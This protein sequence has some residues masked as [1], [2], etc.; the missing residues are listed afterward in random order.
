MGRYDNETLYAAPAGAA[1]GAAG[2]RY[3]N[4]ALYPPAPPAR[5]PAEMRSAD[6]S[7]SQRFKYAV[8]D[9]LMGLGAKPHVAQHLAEGGTGVLGMTPMGSVLAA[10]DL[11]YNA[12]RGNYVNTALDALGVVPGV[13]AA[14]RIVGGMPRIR[15]AEVPPPWVE[16]GSAE[17]RGW[18]T[19]STPELIGYPQ[20][21]TPGRPAVGLLPAE[22]PTPAAP[23]GAAI[24]GYDRI[25]N[26]PIQF[27]PLTGR[28]YQ[29]NVLAHLESP[30][31][32]SFSPASARAVYDTIEHHAAL[33]ENNGRP[34]PASYVDNL[35]SQLRNMPAGPDAAA[36]QRAAR[37]LDQNYLANP[38]PGAVL[39]H[40]L[41]DF[42][43][44]QADLAQARGNYRAGMTA[45]LVEN[46]IDRSGTRAGATYSGMNVDNATRQR[47]ESLQAADAANDKLFAATPAERAAVTAASQGDWLTNQLRAGGKVMGGGGG[48][49]R[50]AA[51][52]AG[53]GFGAA[54]GHTM[55]LDPV[56]T[57]ALSTT[58]GAI[59]FMGGKAMLR[60]ANERTV[61]AAE[62][63]A[64]QIRRASPEYAARVAATPDVIDP[65]AMTRD[66]ITYAMLPQVRQQGED[67]WQGAYSPYEQ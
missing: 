39:P 29:A 12:S 23:A 50:L 19:P 33:W 65:R 5:P 58:A 51:T 47:L 31:G 2:N 8:Q 17:D 3:D 10:A 66:A 32:G 20:A 44:L 35:R 18:V 28:D 54:A 22:P 27:D 59:P 52:S 14:R 30:A 13:T 62:N 55:G 1:A 63:V 34:V 16:R 67:I 42:A 53:S 57:M 60:A 9:A 4:A 45:Q 11:P 21:A 15:P 61:G 46:A 6:L 7:P 41:A 25:R 43:A 24:A 37:F 40:N 26:S 38:T 64:D 48:L 36:G 56:T 49:G